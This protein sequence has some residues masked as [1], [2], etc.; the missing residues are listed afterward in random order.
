M[1]TL[2]KALSSGDVSGAKADLAKLKTDLAAQESTD[3]TNSLAKD[4]TSL[5]K[6]LTSGNTSGAKTDLTKVQKDL[7]SQ[8]ASSTSGSQ[9]TSP[10]DTLISQMDTSL[11]SGSVQG[12]LQ[13]LASYLVQNGQGSGSLVDTSA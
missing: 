10:L 9:T 6:D 12:A 11:N 4:V 7:Q 1:V 2:L 5:L 3:A 13:D 8:E